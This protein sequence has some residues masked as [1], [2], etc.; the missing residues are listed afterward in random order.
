MLG[1]SRQARLELRPL[2]LLLAELG[3]NV[4]LQFPLAIERSAAVPQ[5]IPCLGQRVLRLVVSRLCLA[6]AAGGLLALRF[7]L[8]H[9]RV[10]S[11]EVFLGRGA[12]EVVELRSMVVAARSSSFCSASMVARSCAAHRSRPPKTAS[13]A[14][15]SWMAL[16]PVSRSR[17]AASHAF[18]DA[19]SASRAAC[20]VSCAVASPRSASARCSRAAAP[21]RRSSR[22][23][24]RC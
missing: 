11:G 24:A 23:R 22:S 20:A 10:Q 12:G 17:R 1:K 8:A 4:P 6:I 19:R 14:R 15:A 21:S 5:A 13:S 7:G 18:S 16:R 3:G 2:D 9:R